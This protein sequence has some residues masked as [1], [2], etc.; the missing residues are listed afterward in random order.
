MGTPIMGEIKII[1]WNYAPNGWAM[2]DGQFLPINQNQALFSIL[3]TAYGGNGMTTFA[4]PDLRGRVPVHTGGPSNLFVGQAAGQ[5]SHTLNQNEMPTHNHFIV[6]DTT[7]PPTGSGGNLPA[8]DKRLAQSVGDNLYGAFNNVTPMDAGSI[9]NLGGSQ[10]HENRQPVLALRM[11]IALQ[12][13][14]PSRN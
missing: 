12:G 13:V 10:P 2:C 1:S 11:M 3:G 4:L 8:V 14:F 6:A 9:G 5:P 7:P